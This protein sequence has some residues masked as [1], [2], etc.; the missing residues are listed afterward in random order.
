MYAK[1]SAGIQRVSLQ[2]AD[3]I[4]PD[5]W[6]FLSQTSH[7]VW[8]GGVGVV[9]TTK[10]LV[11]LMTYVLNR[12]LIFSYAGTFSGSTDNSVFT[13]ALIYDL[14]LQRWGQVNKLHSTV[15]GETTLLQNVHSRIDRIQFVGL[16]GTVDTLILDTAFNWTGMPSGSVQPSGIVVVGHVKGTRGRS[17]TFQQAICDGIDGSVT[18]SILP[19]LVGHA[20]VAPVALTAGSLDGSTSRSW[21]GRYTADNFDL[22][23]Q[24]KLDLTT[25]L[26]SVTQHGS[27]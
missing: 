12:Y 23:L 4:L 14:Q 15:I 8:S 5:V 25:I 27:R 11:T 10:N 16:D 9:K 24:G 26:V 22:V 13:K 1:T 3:T 6:D 18:A 7:S 20:R 19:A 2:R 17:V 21:R